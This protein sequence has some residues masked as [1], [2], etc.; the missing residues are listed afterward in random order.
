MSVLLSFCSD[1]HQSVSEFQV[2]KTT[3]IAL[4]FSH[5]IIIYSQ[6]GLS[7]DELVCVSMQI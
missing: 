7:L 6:W 3:N 5:S 2:D 4:F 1:S